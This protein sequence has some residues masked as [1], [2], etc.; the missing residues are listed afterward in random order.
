LRTQELVAVRDSLSNEIATLKKNVEEENIKEEQHRIAV[1]ITLKSIDEKLMQLSGNVHENLT[2]ISE[3]NKKTGLISS[4][5]AEKARQDSLVATIKEQER[6]DLFN[7]AKSNYDKGSFALA[8]N[9]FN[10]YI[11][12]YPDSDDA[13]TA[14]YWKA[15]ANYAMN[16]LDAAKTL[17]QQYYKEN[18]TENFACLVLYKLGLIYDKQKQVKNRDSMWNMLKT[19][20]PDSKE[21]KL[22]I[23]NQKK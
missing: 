20:C 10:D 5:M 6:L 17:F 16:S 1:E 3:I 11:Q 7:L 18:R 19:E 23:E 13:K 15:E 22:V 9:D 2:K 8:I 21:A 4:Q 14:L 12:K